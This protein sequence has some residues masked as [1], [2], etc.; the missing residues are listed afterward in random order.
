MKR[1]KKI[2]A[3]TL[4][5]VWILF[6][7]P[8]TAFAS[9][10][11]I[12]AIEPLDDSVA[13]QK[14]YVNDAI[15]EPNLP[16]FLKVY[17]QNINNGANY[18]NVDISWVLNQNQNFSTL[19]A[20][21]FI[22]TAQI[23]DNQN[24]YVLEE[25]LNLPTIEVQIIDPD[26]PKVQIAFDL[27][28][29]INFDD[30]IPLATASVNGTSLDNNLISYT[31]TDSFNVTY[32]GLPQKGDFPYNYYSADTYHITATIASTEEYDG[33]TITQKIKII[34]DLQLAWVDYSLFGLTLI[35]MNQK[36]QIE[37]IYTIF[38]LIEYAS[39]NSLG[40]L[41][42]LKQNIDPIQ[43]TKIDLPGLNPD[44]HQVDIVYISWD[45]GNIAM[46][47]ASI[48][49][50]YLEFDS[51]KS[52]SFALFIKKTEKPPVTPPDHPIV[53]DTT[54][55]PIVDDTTD[56]DLPPS[57]SPHNNNDIDK[58]NDQPQDDNLEL[59]AETPALDNIES[60]TLNSNQVTT[61]TEQALPT[62][63]IQVA[64]IEQNQVIPSANEAAPVANTNP[65]TETYSSNSSEEGVDIP[66]SP[67]PLAN[68]TNPQTGVANSSPA[69]S[70]HF[71][72]LSVGFR[73]KEWDIWQD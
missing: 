53:D 36:K 2:I 58:N 10:I 24:Q 16:M 37:D 8:L 56:T 32:D 43:L 50:D 30:D 41:L 4:F 7:I 66:A 70:G 17:T 28:I 55:P 29:E 11:T 69:A 15:T 67:T 5:I 52:D 61:I 13:L 39:V 31:Y 33:A 14:Y 47:K 25:G 72:K 57:Q 12:T 65:I 18:I 44:I 60:Q 48:F 21:T 40:E 3:I 54:D 64:G 62:A 38:P 22:Y 49:T 6:A 42:Y 19:S 23:I 26:K 51:S 68:H 35:E 73:K 1:K 59:I 45:D 46:D 34:E 27:P 20:T 63:D 9:D 71:D